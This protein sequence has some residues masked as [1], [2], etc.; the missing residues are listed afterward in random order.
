M[1]VRA[2]AGIYPTATFSASCKAPSNEDSSIRRN[3]VLFS[4]FL[5][6]I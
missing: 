2:K 4:E 6:V 1:G 5:R 3:M